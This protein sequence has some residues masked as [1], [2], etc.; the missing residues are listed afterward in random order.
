ML[1]RLLTPLLSSPL[2]RGGFVTALIGVFILAMIP[3]SAVPTVVSYQDKV[4]HAVAFAGLMLIGWAGWPQCTKPVAAG[5][6]AYGVLI[7]LCQ[8]TLTTNRVGDPWDVVADTAGIFI[9][10][11]LIRARAA[12]L[13]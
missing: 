7:E 1:S 3:L 9:G 11:W 12:R 4:E 13:V 2:V 5:L 6:M 8:H 10:A